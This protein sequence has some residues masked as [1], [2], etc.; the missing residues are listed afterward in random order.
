MRIRF[1]SSLVSATIGLV[2]ATCLAAAVVAGDGSP[3]TVAQPTAQ[4]MVVVQ[5]VPAPLSGFYRVS[6]DQTPSGFPVPRYV[7]LKFGKVNAR[8][9]PSRSHPVAYQYRRR[10]LPLIVVAE[11]EMW[12]KVRDIH[13]D[14]AWVRK[15]ALSGER[16]AM[17][18]GEAVLR[19]KTEADSRQLARIERGA[20]VALEDCK[21]NGICRVRTAGGLKGYVPQRLLWGAQP[22]D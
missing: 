6:A 21:T 20:L 17:L 12:R 3:Q 19:A 16:F 9:G 11:T 14:E 8:T 15:P 13:G 18:T 10:G 5:P 7:S 4:T 1:P 2:V 22:L